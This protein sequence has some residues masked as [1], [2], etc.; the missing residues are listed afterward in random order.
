MIKIIFGGSFNPVHNGHINMAVSAHKALGGEVLFVPA[1]ISVWK[2][3]SVPSQDKINM[4][5]I[6][7]KNYPFL[8]ID[9]FEIDSGK[10]VNYSID[11]VRYFKNK[12][13]EDE[14]YFLIGTDQVNKFHLWKE[15]EE[16]SKMVKLIYFDRP[17]VQIENENIQKFNISKIK[18]EGIVAA[19][20]E[21]T[22]LL[23]GGLDPEV[24]LYI[25][26]HK[27]YFVEDLVKYIPEKRLDHSISV[28]K[29]SYQIALKHDYPN[30]LDALVG[31]L[32]H[33]IGKTR[34]IKFLLET[35]ENEFP[36]YK[37]LPL[38]V[39]HQFL[40][41][42]IAKE[43]FGISNSSV[44]NAIK[45]HATGNENMDSLAKIIYASDKIEPTRNFDSTDLINAMM[46]DIDS[47][48]SIVLKANK[49]FL[50]ETGK[51]F[52]NRLTSKCFNQYL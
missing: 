6:A 17:D 1:P 27:L 10:T 9:T 51:D 36:E 15:A 46:H 44:L 12:F 40:S 19:S 26:E 23:S 29:L 52:E 38:P 41:Y 45:Y 7:I 21:I 14:L 49:E 32:L 2:T 42:K 18:G 25:I 3:D 31:G 34:D 11:T 35:I 43:E 48:F 20:S 4:L 37:D 22:K 16:I 33:D 8:K 50:E 47:G 39:L 28:A 5:E 30:P 13:P 24:L